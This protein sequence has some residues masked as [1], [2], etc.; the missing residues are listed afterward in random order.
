M[1][2]KNENNT[3]STE[4]LHGVPNNL[5]AQVKRLE[6][7]LCVAKALRDRENAKLALSA[8]EDSLWEAEQ[9]AKEAEA[10]IVIAQARSA[11]A[12]AFFVAEQQR[13]ALAAA[14]AEEAERIYNAV[15][16]HLKDQGVCG[17]LDRLTCALSPVHDK[18]TLK[19]AVVQIWCN[20]K[21]LGTGFLVSYEDKP[22]V[23]ACAHLFDYSQD[24]IV[25]AQAR[26]SH[27][28]NTMELTMKDYTQKKDRKNQTEFAPLE[29]IAILAPSDD[30]LQKHGSE[31]NVIRID[32]ESITTENDLYSY[33]YPKKG[34]TAKEFEFAPQPI[35]IVLG[36]GEIALLG[37]NTVPEGCSG[38][39]IVD[40]KQ[41]YNLV[42][43][44][45]EEN[46]EGI[47]TFILAKTIK[48][49]LSTKVRGGI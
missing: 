41:K 48:Q 14:E 28:G 12:A 19:R 21:K 1:S 33:G 16:K 3:L 32:T 13:E 25:S 30:D 31:L 8:M 29:D 34:R 37:E 11:A 24:R 27:S 18:D 40:R 44:A 23:I 36:M 6:R 15:E 26:I 46:T 4:Q 10:A 5:D 7:E 42:G 38:S 49:F 39:P 43:M 35:D 47:M 17:S 20:E 9:A 22:Y 45:C 2:S